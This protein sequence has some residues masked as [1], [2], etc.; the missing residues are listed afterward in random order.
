MLFLQNL[1]YITRAL[2][3]ITHIIKVTSQN[4]LVTTA[5]TYI[6][7]CTLSLHPASSMS[8]KWLVLSQITQVQLIG[9]CLRA[10]SQITACTL[11]SSNSHWICLYYAG[12]C[13]KSQHK[14]WWL[15]S[16]AVFQITACAFTTTSCSC[17]L[18]LVPNHTSEQVFFI[19]HSFTQ[20]VVR[21]LSL[22]TS[23]LPVRHYFIYSLN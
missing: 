5:M 7:A 8:L 10:P 11:T 19:P 23:T 21:A 4:T 20:S 17:G 1:T 9:S 15:N 2:S 16:R 14:Q 3:Q 13:P 6:T 18:G 12:P 22:I